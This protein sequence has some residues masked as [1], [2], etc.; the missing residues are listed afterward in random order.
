MIFQS[1]VFLDLTHAFKRQHFI[2][3]KHA[4][5]PLVMLRLETELKASCLRQIFYF[6]HFLGFLAW[7]HGFKRQNFVFLNHRQP[8]EQAKLTSPDSH[9]HWPSSQSE[10]MISKGKI[11]SWWCSQLVP[12]S[13]KL[14]HTISKDKILSFWNMHQPSKQPNLPS[15]MQISVLKHF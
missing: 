8:L 12:G 10:R 7:A 2:F 3:F 1:G 9:P 11:L 4:P 5:A 6:V 15:M 13:L 14:E